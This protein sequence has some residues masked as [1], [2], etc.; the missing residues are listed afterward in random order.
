MVCHL[1]GAPRGSVRRTAHMI[2]VRRAVRRSG[3]GP[4][5][6]ARHM[7]CSV[8]PPRA[9]PAAPAAARRAAGASYRLPIAGQPGRQGH[10][11]RE[12]EP[13]VEH[14][15]H[16]AREVPAGQGRCRRPVPGPPRPTSRARRRRP[17]RRCSA[18]TAWP[19]ATPG[20]RPG[21]RRR[22]T[23]R[24]TRPRSTSTTPQAASATSAEGERQ[25]RG[26]RAPSTRGDARPRP[27][28]RTRWPS[29]G[30]RRPRSARPAARPSSDGRTEADA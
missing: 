3:R 17:A 18:A 30:R 28:S 19:P 23:T 15:G 22:A 1:R 6:R 9:R 24:R 2:G 4:S 26:R 21:R 29:P 11:D 10:G 14:G 5:S 20:R 12:G 13:S 25:G 27:R 7:S 8:D 16:G